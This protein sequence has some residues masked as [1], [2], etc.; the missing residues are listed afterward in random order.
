MAKKTESKAVSIPGMGAVTLS[1]STTSALAKTHP[2]KAVINTVM[3]KINTQMSK[4]YGG[5][6]ALQWLADLPEKTVFSTGI[7]HL[8]SLLNG[9]LSHG[10]LV[11][12]YGKAQSGRTSLA[13]SLAGQADSVLY[14]DGGRKITLEWARQFGGH[15]DYIIAQP[16]CLEEAFELA[17]YMI[18]AGTQLVI[19]DSLPI[20]PVSRELEETNYLKNTG[21]AQ[22]AGFLARKLPVLKPLLYEKQ[23]TLVII[24][25][26]RANTNA[27]PFG[28]Q[29]HTFGGLALPSF[30]DTAL[31][32]ARKSWM[33][34]TIAGEEAVI[35]HELVY[36]V[37]KSGHSAPQ[38]SGGCPLIFNKGFIPYDQL[39]DVKK[40][41]IE[42][43]VSVQ[44]IEDDLKGDS[45]G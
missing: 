5:S 10:S 35:G 29:Y 34:Q 17:R 33:K 38:Q 18:N 40:E 7:A 16:E 41:L 12:L 42:E 9:G 43:S 45:D 37:I 36:Q 28:E 4:R 19:L 44:E 24:N 26:L 8:D 20:L 31:V 22:T 11:H 6:V 25:D 1:T 15:G 14:I 2:N 3:S 39:K 27:M 13:L 30:A 21:M 23:A 32:V